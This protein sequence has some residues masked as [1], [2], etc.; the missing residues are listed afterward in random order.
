[1]CVDFASLKEI[2]DSPLG[3]IAIPGEQRELLLGQLP[4]HGFN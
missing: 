2:I 4:L 3:P 1:V